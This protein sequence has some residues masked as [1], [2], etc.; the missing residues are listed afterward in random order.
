MTFLH[1]L[2]DT[3]ITEQVKKLEKNKSKCIQFK[4]HY[5]GL[6]M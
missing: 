3:H 5:C 1:Q 6:Q 4:W 2:Q